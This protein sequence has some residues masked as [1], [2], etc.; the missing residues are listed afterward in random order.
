[1]QRI[2]FRPLSSL[3][4]SY[5]KDRAPFFCSRRNPKE[6]L[7]GPLPATLIILHPSQDNKFPYDALVK[8]TVNILYEDDR[9]TVPPK[10]ALPRFPADPVPVRLPEPELATG[11]AFSVSFYKKTYSQP[12]TI[13]EICEC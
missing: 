2:L 9:Q 8:N 10:P 13:R 12:V 4:A 5:C 1:M 7:L 3:F 11:T 6:E